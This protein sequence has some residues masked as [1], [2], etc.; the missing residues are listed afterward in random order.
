[1]RLYDKKYFA[2]TL[3][4]LNLYGKFLIFVRLF[5]FTRNIIFPVLWMYILLI[6]VLH[7]FHMRLIQ[8]H[9]KFQVH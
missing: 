5:I 8:W 9:P 4:C 2:K 7:F 3:F 1:M 6:Y